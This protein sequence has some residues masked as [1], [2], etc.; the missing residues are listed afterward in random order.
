MNLDKMSVNV[1]PLPPYQALDLGLSMARAW[2]KELSK[3]WS[4][5]LPSYTLLLLITGYRL[6]F[7]DS[8]TVF[9]TMWSSILMLAIF[10]VHTEIAMMTLLSQKVFD[11]TASLA[12][13]NTFLKNKKTFGTAIRH[14]ISPSRVVAFAVIYLEGQQGNAKSKRLSSLMRGSGN[15]IWLS[16][17]SFF[18]VEMVLFWGGMSLFLFFLD[19]SPMSEYGRSNVSDFLFENAN[20]RLVVACVLLGYM[21][22]MYVTTP[23]FVASAFAVYLCR[24]SLG[25]GWD[26]ELHFRQMS[27]RYQAL[28]KREQ[29]HDK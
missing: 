3:C 6:I 8:H 1:R 18:V 5:M 25:E 26:I 10:R 13:V 19:I 23:F 22:V 21:A 16:A 9:I 24:R 27:N 11:Q 28:Q 7:N 15:A 20:E 14:A 29:R 2:H 12:S 4:V 17:L